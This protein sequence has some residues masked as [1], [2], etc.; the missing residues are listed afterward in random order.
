MKQEEK[1]V[2]EKQINKADSISHISLY[3]NINTMNLPQWCEASVRPD[4][5]KH[6]Q[7]WSYVVKRRA[8]QTG[9]LV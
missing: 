7:R 3:V 9:S 2:P 5:A 8:V 6:L 4:C 1:R